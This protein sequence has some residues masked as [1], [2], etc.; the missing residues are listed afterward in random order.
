MVP[1]DAKKRMKS[2][3]SKKCNLQPTTDQLLVNLYQLALLHYNVNVP[4]KSKSSVV[5]TFFSTYPR[6][7]VS[8]IAIILVSNQKPYFVD[9]A[10]W[11][12]VTLIFSCFY[13]V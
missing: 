12:H 10:I 8:I 11:K 2:E 6:I 1:K 13:L 7:A 9:R 5:P 3:Q 4:R